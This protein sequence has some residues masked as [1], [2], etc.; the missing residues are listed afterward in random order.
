MALSRSFP[1]T[2]M[3]SS[4]RDPRNFEDPLIFNNNYRQVTEWYD[5]H[6]SYGSVT[7]HKMQLRKEHVAPFHEFIMVRTRGSHSYRVDRGGDGRLLDTMKEQGVPPRDVIAPLQLSS[8]KQ[9]DKTSYCVL[10]SCWGD[11]KTIDLKVVLDICFYIHNESGKR[12]KLLT[13]NCYFFAQTI[14]MIA[15]RKTVACRTKF[16]AVN[17]ALRH[18]I[19]WVSTCI[20]AELRPE[21]GPEEIDDKEEE[22][23]PVVER[24]LTN[25]LSEELGW[26][27]GEELRM[28][29]GEIGPEIGREIGH[30]LGRQIGLHMG[31]E[32]ARG[33]AQELARPELQRTREQ[34]ERERQEVLQLAQEYWEW[35]QEEQQKEQQ[36]IREQWE[37]E[38]VWKQQA[39]KPQVQ[40]EGEQEQQLEERRRRKWQWQREQ[41][42]AW[43]EQHGRR[44]RQRQ[45]ALW[46]DQL[47]E[48]QEEEFQE[49][50]AQ[51]R[52]QL[53]KLELEWQPVL[54]WALE[55]AQE[56]LVEAL[57]LALNGEL[58]PSWHRKFSKL[59]TF[60]LPPPQLEAIPNKLSAGMWYVSLGGHVNLSILSNTLLK[61]KMVD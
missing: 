57:E 11:D 34:W 40:Q 1:S 39:R 54:T 22:V 59:Y 31:P 2:F 5:D 37:K 41:L 25:L 10:E 6:S 9:L 18:I 36:G 12:Y 26:E 7:I 14:F 35:E 48:L 38:Q 56:V 50:L 52:A 15:V 23:G 55:L 49:L 30:E 16:R 42:L 45:W 27:L 44:Q 3:S 33:L 28:A 21:L 17:E 60:K 43:Q 53:Q 19:T 8:W 61:D 29:V 32:L 4:S 24:A 58:E 20:G 51:L 13:H 47:R 46:G